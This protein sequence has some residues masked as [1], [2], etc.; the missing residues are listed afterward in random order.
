MRVCGAEPG[1]EEM[2]LL[3]PITLALK[4]Q[5]N[6]QTTDSGGISAEQ[7]LLQSSVQKA[8]GKPMVRVSADAGRGTVDR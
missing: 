2:R 5:L 7:W 3:H 6:T 1:P 8:R 4:T